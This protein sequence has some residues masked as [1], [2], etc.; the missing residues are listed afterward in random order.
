MLLLVLPLAL[1]WFAVGFMIWLILFFLD[2]KGIPVAS[3]Y[4]RDI[5][6][7]IIMA[8]HH[9]ILALLWW[10]ILLYVYVDQLKDGA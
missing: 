10:P 4:R 1:A 9:F 7:N 6:M 3:N 2:E 8:P 5:V